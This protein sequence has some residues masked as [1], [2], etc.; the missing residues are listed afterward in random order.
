MNYFTFHFR[1]RRNMNILFNTLRLNFETLGHDI[2]NTVRDIGLK[3]IIEILIVGLLIFLAFRFLKGRKA[4]AL[5]IG[6]VLCVILLIIADFFDLKVLH[7]ILSSIVGSGTIVIIVIFQP[8]IREALERIGSGSINGLMSFSDRKKK[9]EL[10]HSVIDNICIAVKELSKEYTGALIVIER[11]TRLSEIIDTGIIINADV[12][13]S[14]IRNLFYNRAPLHDGA[15]VIS[16]GRLTAA[17]C[18]LPLTRRLDIDPDL[19][20]RHRAAI[21][22]SESSDAVTIIVSEETG[23]I[24]VA[25]DCTLKRDLTIDELRAFLNEVILRT[26]GNSSDK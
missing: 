2:V 1:S 9:K 12:S 5:L 16:E 22:M 6:I 20:T 7:F 13:S 3:D 23:K 25:Y 21:G 19:G 24:S 14:L 17:G 26:T 18:F 10:Y 8:E 15:V 11:T 4:G